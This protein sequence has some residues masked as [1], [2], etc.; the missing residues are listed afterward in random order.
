MN[1]FIKNLFIFLILFFSCDAFGKMELARKLVMRTLGENPTKTN[2]DQL[3]KSIKIFIEN[4]YD[5]NKNDFLEGSVTKTVREMVDDPSLNDANFRA[6]LYTV[7]MEI[8]TRDEYPRDPYFYLMADFI[9][10]LEKNSSEVVDIIAS[11]YFHLPPYQEGKF[12]EYRLAVFEY[13]R[14]NFHQIHEVQYSRAIVLKWWD[15]E[16]FRR[17]VFPSIQKE[18]LNDSGFLLRWWKQDKEMETE[19][20]R[21]FII[22]YLQKMHGGKLGEIGDTFWKTVVKVCNESEDFAIEVHYVSKQMAEPLIDWSPGMI[23]GLSPK[24]IQSISPR[25]LA[26]LSIEQVQ[27]FTE[28]QIALLNPKQRRALFRTYY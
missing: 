14:K 25:E 1:F 11:P 2:R 13:I 10:K 5:T 9:L 20:L 26:E 16:D 17:T 3:E 8:L 24:Q 6:A 7:S 12:N 4:I 19:K 15:Q 28:E 21:T 22:P 23:R 18:H 27:G